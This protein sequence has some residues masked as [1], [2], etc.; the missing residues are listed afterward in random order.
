[1]SDENGSVL[2]GEYLREL[3][4]EVAATRGCLE[5]V[6]MGDPGW[7]P[8][9][10][11]MELG[12]MAQLVADMP[13]W[14]TYAIEKGEVDFETYPVF[15]GESAEEIVRHFDEC[16]EGARAALGTLTDEGL[17]KKFRLK[18]GEEIYS[19]QSVR[20][21]IGSTINHMVHHRGQLTVYLRML[22]QKLPSIY[23]PSADSGGF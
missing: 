1:M 13:R 11:S 14:I 20:E 7:K 17:E 19:E 18:R 16:V 15:K 4:S 2:A 12:Y 8:H 5:V 9:E 3:E 22:D 10:R 6:P 23:G 21:T